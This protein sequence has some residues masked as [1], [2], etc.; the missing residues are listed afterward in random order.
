VQ[1]AQQ[2][3]PKDKLI[4]E[5]D[6]IEIAQKITTVRFQAEFYFTFP[7]GLPGW[8]GSLQDCVV[9]FLMNRPLI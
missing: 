6:A 9:S 5:I 2:P 1:A 8:I 7:A 3:T 4:F